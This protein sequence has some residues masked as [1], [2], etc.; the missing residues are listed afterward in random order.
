MLPWDIKRV[1]PIKPEPEMYLLVMERV[2][3]LQLQIVYI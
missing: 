2:T 3:A 1:I